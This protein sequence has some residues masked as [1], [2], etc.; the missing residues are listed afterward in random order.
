[1]LKPVEKAD[2]GEECC[3]NYANRDTG[4]NIQHHGGQ[5]RTILWTCPRSVSTAFERCMTMV[6]NGK[7]FNE[8]YSAA[9][10][11][12]P[13]RKR[14]LFPRIAP[15]YSYKHCKERLEA[16]HTEFDFIFAKEFPLDMNLHRDMLPKGYKHTFLIRHPIKTYPSLR[17]M[18]RS[19]WFLRIISCGA[20]IRT[21][22]A[23]DRWFY[24]DMWE[25]YTYFKENPAEYSSPLIIDADDLIKDPEAMIKKYCQ[26]IGLGFHPDMLTWEKEKLRRL[27]WEMARLLYFGNWL[28]GS[29]TNALN[30]TG[31]VKGGF[32]KKGTA[33]KK[34]KETYKDWCHGC[35]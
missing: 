4:I 19:S 14:K 31:F 17:K 18:F 33:S 2:P 9:F 21:F 27:P 26:S 25:L 34:G 12:G 20:K 6:P 22:L 32:K 24:Q 11:V 28:V 10:L 8:L 13:D 1:M 30:S 15:H 35:K 7:I 29:Y 16:E 23:V 5:I 3:G